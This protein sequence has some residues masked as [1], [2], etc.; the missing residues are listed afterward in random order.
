MQLKTL[1]TY[2]LAGT[3][4]RTRRP[5]NAIAVNFSMAEVPSKPNSK[6]LE[7]A[8]KIKDGLVEDMT[9]LFANRPIWS[10]AALQCHIQGASQE[11]LKQL[12]ASVSYYWLNGPWRALWTRIGYDPRKHPGAKM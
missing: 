8:S 2:R 5:V 11:R 10:R 7:A 3:R 6:A 9:K 1:R 12:L 4:T